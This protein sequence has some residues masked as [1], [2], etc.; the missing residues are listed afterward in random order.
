MSKA[1]RANYSIIARIVPFSVFDTS[2]GQGGTAGDRTIQ[3]NGAKFDRSV[4][5]EL[6][7]AQGTAAP[8]VRYYRVSDTRLYATLTCVRRCAATIRATDQGFH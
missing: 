4:T 3:I 2:Y 5:V 6:V 8:A 1:D 7:D